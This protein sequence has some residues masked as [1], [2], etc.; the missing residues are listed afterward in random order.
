MKHKKQHWIPKSYLKAWCDLNTPPY[1]TPYVWV[2]PREG[3]EGKNKSPKNLFYESEMYTIIEKDGERDLYLEK[4]LSEIENQ[5]TSV[6]RKVLYKKKP[7][8]EE[9]RFTIL[10]FIASTFSRSQQQRD[11]QR[12]QWSEMLDQMEEM[13]KVVLA[14]P[15]DQRKKF[16]TLRGSGTSLALSEVEKIAEHPLQKMMA[17]SILVQVEL[18]S[19]LRMTILCT[20]NNLGF[21]TSDA[22]CVW[23]DPEAFKRPFP[24]NNVG[25]L[26]ETVEITLPIAPC[27][28]VLL[29]HKLQNGYI[30]VSDTIVDDLNRRTRAYAN[31]FFVVNENRTKP[32]W[33]DRGKPPKDWIERSKTLRPK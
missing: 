10:K 2:F 25:L 13:K 32:I 22:P 1:Q 27:Q 17:E 18:L 23:Y 28:L 14:T 7:V 3:G 29:T 5:F 16:E 19:K 4:I 11:H 8:D 31:N 33:F 24:Y 15:P 21:I 6:R 20:D 26:F 9:S 30:Y 12:R